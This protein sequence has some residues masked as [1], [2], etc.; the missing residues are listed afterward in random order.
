M[1]ESGKEHL[2]EKGLL[3]QLLMW[4]MGEGMDHGIP[5]AHRSPR[6]WEGQD[7]GSSLASSQRNTVLWHLGFRTV[8]N[9]LH[10]GLQNNRLILLTLFPGVSG[11]WL[12]LLWH[13]R[14]HT[15]W[16]PGNAVWEP[17]PLLVLLPKQLI[18]NVWFSHSTFLGI[19]G[20]NEKRGRACV[21]E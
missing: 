14:K 5:A 2:A 17:L 21:A 9:I 15:H 18:F 10:S 4:K 8:W 11:T 6:V 19:T 20:N 1:S 12:L 7:T 3:V 13:R 16:S